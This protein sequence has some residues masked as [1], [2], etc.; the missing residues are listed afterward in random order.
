MDPGG[1]LSDLVCF[2]NI[3]TDRWQNFT[4]TVLNEESLAFFSE[5]CCELLVHAVDVEGKAKGIESDAA[6]LLGRSELPATY[7]GGI[8]SFEDLDRLYE[9][10]GGRVDFTVGSALDIFGGSMRFEDVVR[11]AE[12]KK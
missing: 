12:E 4:D 7:A 11:Y 1:C 10:G 9:L 8:A 6:S 5:N 2:H 3:V